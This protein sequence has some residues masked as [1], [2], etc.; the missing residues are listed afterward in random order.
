MHLPSQK[1]GGFQGA[2][3]HD[4]SASEAKTCDAFER[5]ASAR[6]A[7][8]VAGLSEELCTFVACECSRS[9]TASPWRVDPAR[10][11]ESGMSDF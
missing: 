9:E 6:Q 10:G 4:V 1:M 2:Y 3:D 8:P 7:S 11:F 5:R